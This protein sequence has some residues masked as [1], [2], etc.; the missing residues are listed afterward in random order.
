MCVERALA[1]CGRLATASLVLWRIVCDVA[2]LVDV[3]GETGA[4]FSVIACCCEK[5]WYSNRSQEQNTGCIYEQRVLVPGA[6]DESRAPFCPLSDR[7][8]VAESCTDLVSGV[9]V[10]HSY[11]I[12]S[13]GGLSCATP[14]VQGQEGLWGCGTRPPEQ[15]LHLTN[16][17]R[18]GLGTPNRATT[19]D[20]QTEQRLP[21]VGRRRHLPTGSYAQ[22]DVGCGGGGG[23]ED[24]SR[25]PW[26][27][28]HRDQD[29][30]QSA[31]TP[32]TGPSLSLLPSPSPGAHSHRQRRRPG[33]V[34]LWLLS[35][36]PT[37]PDAAWCPSVCRTVRGRTSAR[38]RRAGVAVK[39]RPHAEVRLVGLP[40]PT[41]H[42]RT[43]AHPPPP[44][45]PHAVLAPKS[46]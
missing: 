7:A 5:R 8:I 45:P 38:G 34:T 21:P 3:L 26:R 30:V 43:R 35:W 16:A 14:S 15:V 1:A 10:F 41:L 37:S 24:G 39:E 28:Y 40:P 2:L 31:R 18:V 20:R 17:S 13:C 6:C 19:A 29:L 12:R 4:L 25:W 33:C 23:R 42:S 9:F 46:L 22:E 11:V 36:S 32:P 44:A 27:Q